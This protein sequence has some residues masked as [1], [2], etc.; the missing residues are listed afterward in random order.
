MAYSSPWEIHT[1]AADYVGDRFALFALGSLIT[2]ANLN[3]RIRIPGTVPHLGHSVVRNEPGFTIVYACIVAAHLAITATTVMLAWRAK[4]ETPDLEMHN[5]GG[6]T[7]GMESRE[8]LVGGASG[9][10]YGGRAE[11][12]G[13]IRGGDYD[14]GERRSLET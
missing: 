13:S 9:S 5:M 8:E 1:H 3:P 11:E 2:M 6:N 12:R 7:E 14:L 10:E 4:R